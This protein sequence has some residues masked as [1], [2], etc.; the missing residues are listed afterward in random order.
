MFTNFVQSFSHWAIHRSTSL[1]AGIFDCI[2]CRS[3][4]N[5]FTRISLFC[6]FLIFSVITT[7]GQSLLEDFRSV[8]SVPTVIQ[9]LYSAIASF[10]LK[11]FTMSHR[12]SARLTEAS[13]HL[14]ASEN[15]STVCREIFYLFF[16]FFGG[17]RL[18]SCY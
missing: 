15:D 11:D 5:D 13:G 18:S 9:Q 17:R 12:S 2:I 1:L 14:W 3:L 16:F 4:F 7:S 10:M 6:S 8:S